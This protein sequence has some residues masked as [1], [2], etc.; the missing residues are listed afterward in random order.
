MVD[1]VARLPETS[2]PAKPILRQWIGSTLQRYEYQYELYCRA[3]AEFAG[4]YSEHGFK[5]MVLK[6]YSCSLDGPKPE[7]RPTG[8]IDIWLFGQ[9][10]KVD[11][12]LAKEKGIKID[13]SHH[14]HTVFYCRDFIVENHY[15][16]P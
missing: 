9:Q 16:L 5:M 13:K 4:W 1:G 6:G 2:R 11:E 10:K 7:H 14:H 8:D 3:V 15:D 12:V